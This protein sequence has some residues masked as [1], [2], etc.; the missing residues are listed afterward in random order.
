[1]PAGFVENSLSILL[2]SLTSNE[3]TPQGY[4]YISFTIIIFLNMITTKGLVFDIRHFSV[5][6]GP[7]I[8]TT[9]F[10]KGCPLRCM[11]CHNP[12][13]QSLLPENMR[14]SRKVGEKSFDFDEM[15]GREM[16]PYEVIAE[17]QKDIPIYDE[18]GGGVTFSG[19]EPMLQFDFLYRVLE[20]CRRMDIRTAI[21]TCGH[22]PL[23]HFRAVEPLANLFLYDLKL[24]DPAQHKH[25]TRVDNTLILQN[26]EA[27]LS[28]KAKIHIRIPLIPDITDTDE[29]LMGIKNFLQ[30]H[31]GVERIDLLPY[32]DIA[33]SK[34]VR[35]GRDNPLMPAGEYD[36]QKLSQIQDLFIDLNIPVT[37]GG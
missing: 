27:L 21:D 35:L 3:V 1:M 36:S 23:E 22:A 33:R 25:F 4:S 10:L 29:N 26:L 7:G 30:S 34:Y 11:W 18:S 9:V 6:D 14:R 8:R 13:S 32:H 12:E 2:I 20:E 17:L 19:G 31:S 24:I 37:V 28:R 16:T 15:V 5:H